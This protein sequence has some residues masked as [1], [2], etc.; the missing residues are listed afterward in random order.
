MDR[1]EHSGVSDDQAAAIARAAFT[2]ASA[3]G[4]RP[5][6]VADQRAITSAVATV[7]RSDH[8]VDLGALRPIDSVDLVRVVDDP[9]VR[10]QLVRVL[11]VIAL[12]DGLVEQPKLEAVLDIATALHVHAEFVDAIH[13]L[14]L[15]HVRWVAYDMIRANVATIPGMPWLPDDPYGP[16]MPY[17]DDALDPTLHARYDRLGELPDGTFGRAFHE[18]YTTNRYAFAGAE[19]GLVEAWATPHDSLHVLSGYSTSAQGELLVAAFTGGMLDPSFD[20]METHVLPTIL[21]Y[22]LGIDINKGLN[23]GDA[24]R[25]AADPSWRDNFD[26]NVHL[27]LDAEK[28]WTAWDRGRGMSVDV[29]DGHWDFWA[30]TADELDELRDRY[31][32]APLDPALAALADDEVRRADFER[33]GMTPPPPISTVPISDHPPVGP[34]PHAHRHGRPAPAVAP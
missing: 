17:H 22:H 26:G 28:L 30:H 32:V 19:H 29:Y 10:L 2:V 11:A 14:S 4:T 18:H 34:P 16:F 3:G 23:A 21:I 20:L 8:D 6:S 15:N 27:G 31:D 7:F 25:I 9:A 13:Q 5:L 1:D 12:L 33:E 24:A